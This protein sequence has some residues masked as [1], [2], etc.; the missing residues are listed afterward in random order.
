VEGLII[1]FTLVLIVFFSLLVLNRRAA[2]AGVK[3]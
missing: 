1:S 2:R 3:C